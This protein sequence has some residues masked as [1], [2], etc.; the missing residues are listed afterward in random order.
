MNAAVAGVGDK[1]VIGFLFG[2]IRHVTPDEMADYI[3]S[4]RPLFPNIDEDEWAPYRPLAQ[5]MKIDLTR[6]RVVD[7]FRDRRL[8]LLAII[9]NYPNGLD[10]LGEQIAT[11]KAALQI[12]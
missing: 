3:R 11:V 4:G 7:E 10:W 6:E 5:K 2:L 8:D 12:P 1:A 9:I